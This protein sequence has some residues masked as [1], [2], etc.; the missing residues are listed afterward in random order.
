[1]S[2][3]F[4]QVPGGGAHSP[5]SLV[6]MLPDRADRVG[7]EHKRVDAALTGRRAG[8]VFAA[9]LRNGDSW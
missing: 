6:T 1:M 3:S 7:T 5:E 2:S 4:A 8:N 9:P